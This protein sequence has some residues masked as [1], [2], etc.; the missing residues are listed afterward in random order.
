MA[1]HRL[2]FCSLLCSLVACGSSSS[3]GP[4]APRAPDGGAS[5]TPDPSDPV[6]QGI[7][8]V[9]A[10][11]PRLEDRDKALTHD[12]YLALATELARVPGVASAEYV[13]DGLGGMWIEVTGGGVFQW[14]HIED[15]DIA[16]SPALP[17]DLDFSTL[18]DPVA[19]AGWKPPEVVSG[20][21]AAGT[22]AT[23]FPV[24]TINP[25]PEFKADET[26]SCPDEGKIAIIDFY[27]TEVSKKGLLY[28]NEFLV[29]GVELWTRL[30]RMGQAA[31]FKVDI[32]KDDQIN[33]ANFSRI[34]KDY[35]FVVLNGHGGAP[36]PKATAKYHEPLVTFVTPEVYDP[37]K[38]LEGGMPYAEAW[39]KGWIIRDP[40]KNTVNWTPR[41][42]QGVY[43]A[44]VPQQWLISTC[45]SML[46]FTAGFVKGGDGWS[47]TREAATP[48]YN[49]GHALRDKGVKTV[50]GYVTPAEVSVVA[51]NH[52]AFFR[53]TFGGYFSGD[54]P[55]ATAPQTYWPTCMSSQTF[56]RLKATPQVAVYAPK[57][58]GYSLY[59][60]YTDPDPVYLRATCQN[61]PANVHSMMQDFMLKAG[62]PA[63]AFQ[64]C[65][66][67]WWSQGKEP[68]GI[69]DALCSKGEYPTTTEAVTAAGCNVRYA[70]KV[71]LAMLPP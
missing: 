62:T 57:L 66:D 64:T 6:R 44:D 16:H 47:W 25:D 36:G 14:R 54:R 55:P 45:Y 24:A 67:S 52:L 60:M 37:A 7:L 8:D 23:P 31:H 51:R 33:A 18:M 17:E 10:R 39:N 2:V 34:L 68:T 22:Y 71:T 38:Q 40:K 59:T 32:F 61:K 11:D 56:F 53:R 27:Y 35:T 65:W 20:P 28:N 50:F 70:R 21:R 69:Q 41:L 26:V 1:H 5:V 12:D 63:T 13:G 30:E 49:F 15:D 9:I 46:P 19:N 4:S 48:L 3:D 58:D 43:H 42:I 29:D